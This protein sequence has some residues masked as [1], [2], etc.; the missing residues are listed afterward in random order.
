MA[1]RN[2]QGVPVSPD[3]LRGRHA[4]CVVL[5]IILAAAGAARADELS[6]RVKS[7][8]ADRLAVCAGYFRIIAQC[9]ARPTDTAER[10]QGAA[11]YRDSAD[12]LT[13]V[14]TALVPFKTA[15][16]KQK[17]FLEDMKEEVGRD[18][19]NISV[20]MAQ[21]MKPCRQ[22]QEDPSPLLEELITRYGDIQ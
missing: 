15:L 13:E 19:G 18:C 22:I 6:P 14:T 1:V 4:R 10:K 7:E 5:A 12:K 17:L 21:H 11:A 3:R 20:L 8:L 16:A 9:L 2:G